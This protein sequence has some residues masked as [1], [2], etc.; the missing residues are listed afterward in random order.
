MH[1]RKT[2]EV[3]ALLEP[4]KLYMSSLRLNEQKMQSSRPIGEIYSGKAGKDAGPHTKR[5]IVSDANRSGSN[6]AQ[7]IRFHDPVRG[8]FVTTTFL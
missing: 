8:I 1:S 2:Q 5:S 6:C 3:S 7:R 4:Y